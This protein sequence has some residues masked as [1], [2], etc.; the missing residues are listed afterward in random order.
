MVVQ[1][2]VNSKND[3][4]QTVFC[5]ETRNEHRNCS[6]KKKV[7]DSRKFTVCILFFITQTYSVKKNNLNFLVRTESDSWQ[8]KT[9]YTHLKQNVNYAQKIWCLI[10]Y[11]FWDLLGTQFETRGSFLRYFKYFNESRFCCCLF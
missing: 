9:H 10:T 7:S 3:F 8:N 6:I 5:F 4:R 1:V 11:S 2:S